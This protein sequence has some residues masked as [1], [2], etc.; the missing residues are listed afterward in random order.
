[1]ESSRRGDHDKL[2]RL[3]RNPGE[4]GRDYHAIMVSGQHVWKDFGFDKKGTQLEILFPK[5]NHA[6]LERRSFL[7]SQPLL[8]KDT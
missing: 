5:G 3:G 4:R 1:M 8:Q 7:I 2:R 6:G